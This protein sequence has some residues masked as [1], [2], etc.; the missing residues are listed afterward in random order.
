MEYC[1][2]FDGGEGSAASERSDIREALELS[3]GNRAA[4]ASI[5]GISRTTLWRKM[6]EYG[7]ADE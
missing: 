6:R 1:N 7:L 2:S 4:A 5:L 3:G